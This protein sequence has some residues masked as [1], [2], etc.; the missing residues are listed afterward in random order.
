MGAYSKSF[1]TNSGFNCK[2][3][4]IKVEREWRKEVGTKTK[5]QKNRRRNADAMM[6]MRWW[7]EG[8][9]GGG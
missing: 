6:R 7:G 5:R 8:R 1:S 2:S 3:M 4:R 9:D